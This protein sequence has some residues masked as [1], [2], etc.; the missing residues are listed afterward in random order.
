MLKV[1]ALKVLRDVAARIHTSSGYSIM[2]DETTDISN[3]E[4]LTIVLKWVDSAFSVHEEF[5]GL[6]AVPPSVQTLLFL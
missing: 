6:H 5:V 3:Q 2:M 4:Q 1:M